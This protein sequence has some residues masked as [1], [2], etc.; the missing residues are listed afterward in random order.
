MNTIVPGH[1]SPAVADIGSVLLCNRKDG[2]YA[3]Q[4]CG[5]V[6]NCLQ[7]KVHNYKLQN[8]NSHDGLNNAPGR[9]PAGR[10]T[11]LETADYQQ[12]GF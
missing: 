5:V 8:I 10:V 11:G 9:K 12:Y 6:V 2:Q 1:T 4:T 3:L 7:R